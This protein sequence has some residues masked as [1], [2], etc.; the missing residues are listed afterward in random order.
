[1][2][3]RSPSQPNIARGR[4]AGFLTIRINLDTTA[5]VPNEADHVVADVVRAMEILQES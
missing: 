3:G 2:D 4:A 5:G 1:M